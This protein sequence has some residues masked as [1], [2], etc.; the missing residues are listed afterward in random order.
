MSGLI[1]PISRVNSYAGLVDN[2][3]DSPVIVEFILLKGFLDIRSDSPDVG[4]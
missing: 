3:S 1:V 4:S 2:R